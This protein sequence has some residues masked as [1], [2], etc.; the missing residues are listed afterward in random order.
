MQTAI[1]AP[2]YRGPSS[3]PAKE[4]YVVYGAQ[5]NTLLTFIKAFNI[6]KLD[7]LVHIDSKG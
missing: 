4:K 7:K 3:V 6:L 5:C 1:S 2:G